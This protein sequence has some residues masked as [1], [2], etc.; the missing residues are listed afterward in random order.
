MVREYL[1]SNLTAEQKEFIDFYGQTTTAMLRQLDMAV[2]H[3]T[4]AIG[5][6]YWSKQNPLLVRNFTYLMS[7]LNYGTVEFKSNYT[8]FIFNQGLLDSKAILQ[9]RTQAKL[10]KMSLRFDDKEYPT[11]LVKRPSGL[12]QDGIERP[13]MMRSAKLPFQLDTKKLTEYRRPILINLIKSIRKGIELK[14]ISSKF[15]ADAVNYKEVA[16]ML[17][18]QYINN[19]TTSYNSECN[20]QDQ[21]GRA[22]KKV[23]KRVGNYISN[24]DFRACLVIPEAYCTKLL[25]TD[26]DA[27][28]NIYLF[29]AELLGHKCIGQTI[30]AKIQA[31]KQAYATRELPRLDLSTQH[32]RDE[33]H[34]LI[35]LE[36]IYDRLKFV[37]SRFNLSG[38]E[39]NIP[40][41]I[42]HS[43]SVAQIMGALTNDSRILESTG[44]I[45]DKLQDP[46]YIESVRRSS[47][48]AVGTPSLYGSSATAV[49]LLKGK[50]ISIDKAEIQAIKREFSTGRFSVMK[51]FK[52]LLIQNYNVHTPTI[53]IDTGI[54]KFKIEVSHFKVAKFNTL[55]TEAYVNGKFK[56]SFTKVPELVPDYKRMKLYW[57]TCLIHH[58]DSD[59]M[60][61]NLAQHNT[62]WAL[63]IH[64]AILCSP[65]HATSFKQTASNRLKYYNQ[66]RFAI[67][68]AYR[69]SIGAVTAKSDIQYMRLLKSVKDA[70]DAEFQTTLMK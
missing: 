2:V 21:R 69:Q 63:D 5:L 48:K 38:V 56:Y 6:P 28:N 40:I 60:E 16:S 18:D 4:F 19:S 59:L 8:R 9:Y 58:L 1:E 52:D 34:Q 7:K 17:L 61:Y 46:W 37:L 42:D 15:F 11:T 30:E 10:A 35:W 20:V 33:L 27:L 39:W 70:G 44:V 36:R 32:G 50:G 67:V 47:A 13:A 53:D 68:Q 64:D 45:G 22:I 49:K 41:E 14:H 54:S 57:A 24:K 51:Q 29:I 65:S 31:G 55:V 43:M 26:T 23:L 3:N 66:N 25:P 62:I 12:L